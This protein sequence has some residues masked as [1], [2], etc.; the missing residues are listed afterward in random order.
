MAL[1]GEAPSA[2][3][4]SREF[5][6]DL[7]AIGGG[8]T[9]F[10]ISQAYVRSRRGTMRENWLTE[11]YQKIKKSHN[12]QLSRAFNLLHK[13]AATDP[14]V[15]EALR[16]LHPWAPGLRQDNEKTSNDQ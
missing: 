3:K 8:N 1:N 5:G 15:A 2:N 12:E 14:E 16:L 4:V 7:W 11:M 9:A 10:N 6:P 13:K